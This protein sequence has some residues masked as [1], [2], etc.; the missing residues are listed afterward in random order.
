MIWVGWAIFSGSVV[1]SLLFLFMALK[2]RFFFALELGVLVGF[3]F[4]LLIQEAVLYLIPFKYS[5]YIAF[6][7]FA[8][9]FIITNSLFLD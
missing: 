3:L 7:V 5:I 6:G 1:T 9:I 2:N 4:G 8:G